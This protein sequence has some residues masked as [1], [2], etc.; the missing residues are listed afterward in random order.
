MLSNIISAQN[1]QEDE[2]SIRSLINDKY[3]EGW[4]TG[5]SAKV[6]HAMHSTCHLKFY[7]DGQFTDVSRD[8]YLGRFKPRE[9]E[10]T[11]IG[12][13]IT[14]DITGNIASAKCEIETSKTTYIDYFNIIKVGSEWKIVDKIS[15][16]IDK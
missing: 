13:I 8:E 14:L 10:S 11:T 1:K 12:R 9:K 2:S 4:M 5:D 3:F 6:G 16:R 7:R 15:T